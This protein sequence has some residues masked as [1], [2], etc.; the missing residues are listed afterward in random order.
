MAHDANVMEVVECVPKMEEPS[1]ETVLIAT[2]APGF[3]KRSR[4]NPMKDENILRSQ[5]PKKI[6]RPYG[7]WTERQSSHRLDGIESLPAGSAPDNERKETNDHTSAQEMTL[8]SLT[9]EQ[10]VFVRQWYETLAQSESIP[11]LSIENLNALATLT[12]TLPQVVFDYLKNT[13]P[14]ISGTTSVT[15]VPPKDTQNNQ[16]QPR[17]PAS[18]TPPPLM[19]ANTHLHPKTLTLVHK[20]LQTCRRTRPRTDGRRS[21][22]SGPYRC[23][24][25][26]NYTTRRVFDWR[27]HEETHEPQEL[28]LCTLCSHANTMGNIFLVSRKDKFL[29]HARELHGEWKAEKVLKLSRVD[30]RASNQGWTCVKARCGWMG[31]D[32]DERC[33]HV[34]G[35]F[36]DEVMEQRRRANIVGK[37]VKDKNDNG[38]GKT[39]SSSVESD[40]Q[41]EEADHDELNP[42]DDG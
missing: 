26:C 40:D 14:S 2:T 23:T 34:V 1:S 9:A 12:Q 3:E 19:T 42:M 15:N 6:R 7:T 31:G 4:D 41:T 28:W 13:Y 5:T 25:G 8:E 22:N 39:V 16:A 20:F 30:F 36:D 10:Q 32:W 27:R 24:F 18:S 35:H 11:T 37:E 29:R 17:A 33:R 21:V 38:A